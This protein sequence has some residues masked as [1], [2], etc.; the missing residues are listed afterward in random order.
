MSMKEL[1]FLFFLHNSLY[2]FDIVLQSELIFRLGNN[3]IKVSIKDQCRLL[4]E[5]NSIL[6]GKQY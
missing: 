5:V 1:H 3:V 4:V 6:I 2:A